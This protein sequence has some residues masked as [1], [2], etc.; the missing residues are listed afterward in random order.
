MVDTTREYWAANA[1]FGVNKYLWAQLQNHLGWNKSNYG[2]MTPITTPQ[3]QKVFQAFEAPY[4]VYNFKSNASTK[5]NYMMRGDQIAYAIY[6]TKESDVRAA[7]NL[8]T[9]LFDRMDNSAADVNAWM[10]HEYNT[11]S[12]NT[13]KA[14]K[15]KIDFKSTWVLDSDAS[16]PSTEEGGRLDGYL[17]LQTR[18]TDATFNTERMIPW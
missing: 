3:D 12:D 17:V 11:T 8:L 9:Y 2:G 13:L 10:D 7:V 16:Q 14:I 18:Y 1:T 4:I 5:D 6:S 15:D